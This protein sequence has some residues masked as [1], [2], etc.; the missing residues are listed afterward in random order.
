MPLKVTRRKST[1]ALTIS[2]TVA[3]VVFRR[4][5]STNDP[6]LAREEAAI[7]EAKLL[8][9]EWHG[10]R[11]VD[12][13]FSEALQSYLDAAPRSMRVIATLVRLTAALGETP[14]NAI[15]QQTVIDLR[16]RMLRP[17]A[18]PATFLRE[19]LVPLRA[20]LN[21][22]ADQKWCDPP[23]FVQPRV[24][25]GRTR[26][27]LPGEV[28]RLVAAAPPHVRPLLI[29][30]VGTGARMSEAIELDWRD[31]D[32][33]GQ[34]VIFW[35]TKNGRRRDAELPPRVVSV[36]AA[37]PAWSG[38]V[39]RRR[40]GQPYVDRQR[41][42]GGHIKDAWMRAIRRAG[43]D[44]ELTPHDLRHTWA[45]WHYALYRDLLKLKADGGW[46]S[47]T[48]VERYTHLLP[49]GNKQG[50]QEFF[51]TVPAPIREAG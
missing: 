2:G 25:A 40:D 43:L 19:V 10:E 29:F 46:S 28:E 37:L 4:R 12:R 3:G 32:L 36:L 23:R 21:H 6:R 45:S 33:G 13:M 7:I 26:F 5:A 30:L 34:R 15:N 17:G 20:V 47:L 50:I 42:Y 49:S 18:A 8:R 24:G 14:L 22:A 41:Q 1:G 16:G 35:R 44:P 9:A 51:G 27:L 38:P 39:F 31:V 48:L 11:T